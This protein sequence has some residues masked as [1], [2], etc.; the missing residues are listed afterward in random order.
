M[1]LSLGSTAA[2]ACKIKESRVFA[3]S[4]V[5][6]SW[7]QEEEQAWFQWRSHRGDERG[8]GVHE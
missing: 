6:V 8:P 5:V 2:L 4:S 7:E 3:A 1:I